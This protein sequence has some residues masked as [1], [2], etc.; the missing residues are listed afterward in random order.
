MSNVFA[1]IKMYYVHNQWYDISC[2][3]LYF[4]VKDWKTATRLA[5]K[6]R[7][8]V[9]SDVVCWGTAGRSR[10]QFPFGTLECFIDLIFPASLWLW[11]RL[12]FWQKW[13]SGLSPGRN[14]GRCVGLTTFPP[15]C[16][17]CLN[18]LGV[19]TSCSP[20]GL[21]RPVIG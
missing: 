14:D 8:G 21:S 1:I 5:E 9:G 10:I 6:L 19:L 12:S 2:A 16:A 18:I 17:D 15:S 13:V 3:T 4:Y 7:L 11:G 20:K